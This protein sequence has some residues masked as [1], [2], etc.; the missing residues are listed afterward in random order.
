MYLLIGT[1]TILEMFND[2]LI[3]GV[4]RISPGVGKEDSS[5]IIKH[6]HYY[7]WMGFVLIFLSI[8]SYV[9]HY[10][11]KIWEGGK[12]KMLVQDLE[13]TLDED[14]KKIRIKF[15]STYLTENKG[16]FR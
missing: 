3:N 4:H 14:T 12:M 13:P 8:W 15:L 11:W 10:L 16:R 7:Q 2:S 1:F 9:P 5:M 6:Y